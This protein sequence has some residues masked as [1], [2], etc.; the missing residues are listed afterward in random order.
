MEVEPTYVV[1]AGKQ[2]PLPA[3]ICFPSLAPLH[4]AWAEISLE[5]LSY[6]G[7]QAVS[8]GDKGGTVETEYDQN[9][10]NELF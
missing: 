5:N 2:L 10:M 8:L 6:P 4:Q 9:I 3:H 7:P 1:Q